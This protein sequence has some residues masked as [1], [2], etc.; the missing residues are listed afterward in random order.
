MVNSNNCVPIWEHFENKPVLRVTDSKLVEFLKAKGFGKL[1]DG[2]VLRDDENTLKVFTFSE[3]TEFVYNYFMA[4]PEEEFSNENTFGVQKGIKSET[5][6]D[7]NELT[8]TKVFFTKKEVERALIRYS[9]INK[10]LIH[11]LDR[12]SEDKKVLNGNKPHLYTPLFKDSKSEVYTFFDN[13]IVRTNSKGSKIEKYKI[14]K[15]GF[16]WDSQKNLK[17]ENI[18][19]IPKKEKGLF[20]T[21]I[22]KAMSVKDKNGEWK[23]DTKEYEALRTVYGYMLSNHTNNG[24]TPIPIFVDRCSD[25]VNAEGGN[26]KS[27]VMNSVKYW[28]KTSPINGR[29]VRR[30]NQFVFSSIERDTQFIHMDDV[31]SDF[32]F[33]IVYNYATGDMEIEKKGKD[34][35]VIPMETK[36]KIG[37]CTNY[38]MSENNH[39][40]KRRQY[41]VEFGEYWNIQTKKGITVEKELGKRLFE[42]FDDNDWIQFYNFGFRCITEYLKKGVVETDKSDYMR[43]QQIAKIEGNGVNDGVVL[44]IEEFITKHK[45]SFADKYEIEKFLS[46]FII[47]FDKGVTDKWDYKKF[48]NAIWD[49]CKSNNWGYNPHKNGNTPSE[50]RW[51]LGPAGKQTDHIR[52][53]M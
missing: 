12:F 39:S 22:E 4:L 34:R 29:N 53:T 50:R 2:L 14:V 46:S 19:L 16:I 32:P 37:I 8:Q 17:V 10:N 20:E 49:I 47:N 6:D 48:T 33:T 15:D 7:G 44:W 28:K 13:G 43:K 11:F 31:N 25:G 26:G 21:F 52:I 41:I 45:K 9:L 36:P 40:T 27:L 38:I 24:D 35:F 18:Q 23:I 30:D 1:Y 42:E 51:K 3:L 5:D